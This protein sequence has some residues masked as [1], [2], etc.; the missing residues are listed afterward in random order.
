MKPGRSKVVAYK[1]D[2]PLEWLLN[3]NPSV[4]Q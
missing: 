1:L 3:V 4:S 2:N